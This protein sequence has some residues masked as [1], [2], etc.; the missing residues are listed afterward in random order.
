[1]GSCLIS[2]EI[3]GIAKYV[4]NLHTGLSP[5]YRGGYT[6]L[7]PILHND[8][9]Y[10]GVTVHVMSSGIDSGNIVHTA[11][12][13]ITP[14]DTYGSVNSKAIVIGTDLMISTINDLQNSSLIAEKQWTLGKLFH[15]YHFNNFYAYKYFSVRN[16]YFSEYCR[17]GQENKLDNLFIVSKGKRHVI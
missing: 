6:N 12:P 7:W 16:K 10:F 5:Y 14:D 2:S 15:N 9:G 4:L 8:F 17:L 11:R 3:I 1:M 13:T